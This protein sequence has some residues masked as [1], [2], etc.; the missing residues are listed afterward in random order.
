MYKL[1]SNILKEINIQIN[2]RTS[3]LEKNQIECIIKKINKEMYIIN[4]HILVN[5]EPKCG[6]LIIDFIA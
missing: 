6:N 1:S 2:F 3:N 4:I 5:V